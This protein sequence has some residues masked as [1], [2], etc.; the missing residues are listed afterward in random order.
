VSVV[1]LASLGFTASAVAL[2]AVVRWC[3]WTHAMP[4][5]GKWLSN[6][7][8][9]TKHYR[10]VARFVVIE[11]LLAMGLAW[12]FDVQLARR[13]GIVFS[14]A[15]SLGYTAP[16][17]AHITP[18]TA[19][20]T[21]FSREAEELGDTLYVCV[22]LS[23]QVQYYGFLRAYTPGDEPLADRELVL[24]PPLKIQVPGRDLRDLDEQWKR[25]IVH[26][27]LVEAITVAYYK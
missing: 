18:D 22:R 2:L 13:R 19:W 16:P 9:L 14:T 15:R 26:G 1:A 6:S 5:P 17:P 23:N 20:F 12:L 7:D 10:L 11:V 8:Y 24:L 21:T 3:V 25:M 4:D 27:G